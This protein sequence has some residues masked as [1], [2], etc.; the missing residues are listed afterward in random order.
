M[1][2]H[3]YHSE[4]NLIQLELKTLE[5][6]ILRSMLYFFF[7]NNLKINIIFTFVSRKVNT[8]QPIRVAYRKPG[9]LKF[10]MPC[11]EKTSVV[12]WNRVAIFKKREK[13]QKSKV[14]TDDIQIKRSVLKV[15]NSKFSALD[16]FKFCCFSFLT[17]QKKS[18]TKS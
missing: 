18:D 2:E 6:W 9:N 15:S 10:Y 11:N 1:G 7:F 5:L 8:I 14:S 13:E 16:I 3:S 17:N 4:L 12:G